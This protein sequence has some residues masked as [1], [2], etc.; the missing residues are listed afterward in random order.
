MHAHIRIARPVR[1]LNRAVPMYRDGLGIVELGRFED[2]DG[3]DGVMLGAPGGPWHFELTHCRAHPV[4]PAPTPEDLVVL[5][6]PDA[7]EWQAACSRMASAGFSVVSSF[8]PYWETSG[9]T[10]QDHDGYRVVLQCGRWG[11]SDEEAPDGAR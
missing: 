2:H 6:V 5:Y 11:A 4:V 9:R 1:D 8:N 7:D 10:F 3:F